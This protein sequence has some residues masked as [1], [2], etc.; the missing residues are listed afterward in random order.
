MALSIRSHRAQ[1]W[2]LGP[3]LLAILL[4][5]LSI[6]SVHA[7]EVLRKDT[8]AAIVPGALVRI[9]APVGAVRLVADNRRD[10][11]IELIVQCKGELNACEQRARPLRLVTED[12]ERE[13]L[14]IRLDGGDGPWARDSKPYRELSLHWARWGSEGNLKRG[15]GGLTLNKGRL[16]WQ[17]AVDF[18]IHYPA[19]SPLSLDLGHGQVEIL[20]LFGDARVRLDQGEVRVEGREADFD[21]VRLA[22]TKGGVRLARPGQPVENG[23][24]RGRGQGGGRLLVVEGLPGSA[25]LDVEIEGQGDVALSLH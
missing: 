22:T 14:T 21:S 15:T 25:D 24:R 3:A 4:T 2:R 8:R 20:G 7:A 11:R 9:E 1:S 23:K 19:L 10:V 5:T 17:V 13:G 18:T 16:G 12:G 6:P